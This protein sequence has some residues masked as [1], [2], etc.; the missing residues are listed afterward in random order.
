MSDEALK[1]IG[2]SRADVVR[3][4]ELHFWQDPLSNGK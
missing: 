2:L 3:E 1:D 4:S